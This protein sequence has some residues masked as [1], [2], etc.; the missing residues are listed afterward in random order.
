VWALALLG[1][2]F[3]LSHGHYFNFHNHLY[4]FAINMIFPMALFAAIIFVRSRGLLK[5]VASV[6]LAW[7]LFSA[8]VNLY[9]NAYWPGSAKLPYLGSSIAYVSWYLGSDSQTEFL[10]RVTVETDKLGQDDKLLTSPEWDYPHG[11]LRIGVLL[12]HS[13]RRSFIPDY[14]YLFWEDLYAQRMSVFCFLFPNFKNIDYHYGVRHCAEVK[15]DQLPYRG[16][17][18][19]KI[20]EVQSKSDVLPLYGIKMAADFESVWGPILIETYEEL[21]WQEVDRNRHGKLYLTSPLEHSRDRLSFDRARFVKLES[22]YS[23]PFQAPRSGAYVL[24]MAGLN[25]RDSVRGLF[26]T[27]GSTDFTQELVIKWLD[28]GVAE[29][30]FTV[31]SKELTGE[32]SFLLAE[33]ERYENLDP[34]PFYYFSAVV[35]TFDKI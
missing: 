16:P 2:T 30:A 17:P 28:D 6:L 35:Q 5:I 33:D 3:A 9:V 31:D 23:V 4:R 34:S 11:S 21:G 24:K 19:F 13:M 32:F 20:K 10:D 22:T 26:I 18:L 25:L 12:S 14:R 29:V 1:G 27:S 8:S 15:G 7:Q